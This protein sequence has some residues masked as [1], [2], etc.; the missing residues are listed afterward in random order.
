V[1]HG[2]GEY[3]RGEITTN[4]I[5]GFFSIFKRGMKG[6]YQHCAKEHLE[7]YLAEYDFRYNTRS[8]LG[9]E[10]QERT[11][12]ALRGIKGKRLTYGSPRF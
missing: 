4:T 9:I 1:S 6:V 2:I 10:D 5:E 11:T 8:A 12:I 7:R 3:G